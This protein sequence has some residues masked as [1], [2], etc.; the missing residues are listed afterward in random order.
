MHFHIH[1]ISSNVYQNKDRTTELDLVQAKEAEKEYNIPYS[2]HRFGVLYTVTKPEL[3]QHHRVM[4][5]MNVSQGNSSKC[6]F[7]K[8]VISVVFPCLYSLLFLAA[9]VLN[10]LAAWIFF[11]IPSTSTFLVYLKNVVAADLLMTFTVLVKV[12]ND[13]GVGSWR[14][15]AFYCRYSAVLFYA[16]MYISILLLG[17]ISLDRYLKIVHPLGKSVLQKVGFGQGLSAA[18]WV[19]MFSLALPNTVL[20]N[21]EPI[22]SSKLNCMDMKNKA[23]LE[24]HEGFNYF[25]QVLFWCTLV[26][27]VF[28]YTFI[29]RKVYESIRASRSSS[30][31]RTRQTKAKVFIVVVV[32][33]IC[34]APFHF[35]RVPYTLTQTRNANSCW[36]K[37]QLY[38]AKKTALWLCAT[39]ICLDPLIYIFLCRM[40]RRKLTATLRRKPLPLGSA[41]YPTETST[42][43]E[44]SSVVHNKHIATEVERNIND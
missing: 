26:L 17:L 1:T 8:S 27:M 43:L 36:V 28:C 22:Q 34:F 44:M 3:E 35:V 14:L 39:N 33:F 2:T 19:V 6:D 38:I 32:F 13:L 25:C 9:L 30:S 5:S 40:F 18:V 15:R 4:A 23:G 42:R 12:L 16:T 29:S 20:S 10:L 37:Y 41:E 24:W 31:T 11:Q 7:D 21:K